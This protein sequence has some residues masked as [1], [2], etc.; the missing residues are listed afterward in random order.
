LQ[1]SVAEEDED[2][3][4]ELAVYARPERAPDDDEDEAGEWT[5]HA[6]VVVAPADADAQSFTEAW[7]PE[8]AE[9]LDVEFVYDR[10]AERGL[11][12]GPAFQGLRAA[13]QRGDE[14]FAEVALGD[15]AK[16]D[17]DRFGIHPALLD[18]A[19]HATA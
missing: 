4:R 17:A 7:P 13:W 14:L 3:R 1:V 10:L 8:G 11:G 2:G 9:P 15:D 16:G 19:L 5:R 18:A 6:S 12:Y